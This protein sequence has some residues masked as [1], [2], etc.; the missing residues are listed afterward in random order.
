MNNHDAANKI[1]EVVSA[2]GNSLCQAPFGADA[3][4]MG[5]EEVVDKIIAIFREAMLSPDV[6]GVE[7][8]LLEIMMGIYLDKAGFGE[9]P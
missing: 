5:D 3:E 8:D 7:N 1:M 2:Y 6:I 9:K 4:I